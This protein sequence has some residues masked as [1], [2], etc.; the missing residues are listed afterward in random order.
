MSKDGCPV[1][2]S[3]IDIRGIVDDISS[4]VV[5]RV[6]SFVLGC[7]N[8]SALDNKSDAPGGEVNIRSAFETAARASVLRAR[9]NIIGFLS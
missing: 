7:L 1:N 4:V 5:V 6:T 2:G 9:D 8:V 3:P